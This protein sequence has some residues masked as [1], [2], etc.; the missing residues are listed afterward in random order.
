MTTC[1]ETVSLKSV[2]T[3]GYPF[4]AFSPS[5]ANELVV[6]PL[7]QGTDFACSATSAVPRGSFLVVSLSSAVI[8][9]AKQTIVALISFF[10]PRP[11]GEATATDVG[12]CF[13]FV[14][15]ASI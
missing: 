15:R 2:T 13:F 6:Y 9:F 14:R 4:F 8:I 10:Y 5:V 3:V 11:T 1:Y 7:A 12:P